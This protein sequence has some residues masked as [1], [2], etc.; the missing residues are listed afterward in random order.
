MTPSALEVNAAVLAVLKQIGP[1]NGANGHPHATNGRGE[2]FVEKLLALR[3]AEELADSSSEVRVLAGTVITPL[4]RDA[5][6][7]KGVT[8]RVVSERENALAQR[9]IAG[10]WGFAIESAAA[11]A[12]PL[13]RGWLE[14][15]H[16]WV[17]VGGDSL[18]AARWVVDGQGRG[19][20]VVADEASVAT[21]R[22]FQVAGVRPATVADAGA[23]SRAIRHLGVNLIVTEPGDKSLHMIRQIGDRFRRGGAPALPT[24]LHDPTTGVP[25]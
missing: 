24:T 13:R 16:S 1:P 23:V 14:G 25:R 12:E 18:D 17:E 19:A 8:I 3:H 20:L 2:V 15:D 4:A 11:I 7:R 6:R 5:F 9:S 21:W 10:E 22:A